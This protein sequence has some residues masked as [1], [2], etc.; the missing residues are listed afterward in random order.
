[1]STLNSF[2]GSEIFVCNLV[3]KGK[4]H[5]AP[6]PASKEGRSRVVHAP[7]HHTQSA[8]CEHQQHVSN[9]RFPE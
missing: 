9:H 6:F 5:R 2:L 3:T 1:M 4:R 7:L 8:K